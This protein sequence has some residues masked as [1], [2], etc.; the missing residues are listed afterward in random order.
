MK[1]AVEI[2]FN[3]LLNKKLLLKINFFLSNIHPY[4]LMLCCRPLALTSWKKYVI[5]RLSFVYGTSFIVSF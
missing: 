3:S 4:L 1:V 2:D 5:N